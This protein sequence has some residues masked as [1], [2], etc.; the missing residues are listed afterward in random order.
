MSECFFETCVFAQPITIALFRG[1]PR[2]Y[3]GRR[4]RLRR[5]CV[6]RT[7]AVDKEFV[8]KQTRIYNADTDDRFH[9][10]FRFRLSRTFTVDYQ[11]MSATSLDERAQFEFI[12]DRTPNSFPNTFRAIR[13]ARIAIFIIILLHAK[14]EHWIFA[15]FNGRAAESPSPSPLPIDVRLKLMRRG[16]VR[17]VRKP[18]LF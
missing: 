2:A 12:F 5:D 11:L 13:R 4:H 7:F 15:H 10:V 9:G 8:E 16:P 18:I 14:P 3:H 1:T 6:V 17:E